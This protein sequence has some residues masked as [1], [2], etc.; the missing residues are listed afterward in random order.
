ML[1]STI[2]NKNN[3]M[4]KLDLYTLKEVKQA[5]DSYSDHSSTCL[6]YKYICGKI[7]ELEVENETVFDFEDEAE[8]LIEVLNEH[9]T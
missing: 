6:G 8:V 3:I 9:R 7:K 5:L 4:D 1:R 2:I